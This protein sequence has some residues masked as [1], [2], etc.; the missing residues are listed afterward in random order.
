MRYSATRLPSVPL[1]TLTTSNI[2]NWPSWLVCLEKFSGFGWCTSI[3]FLPIQTT[4]QVCPLP[5]NFIFIVSN[6]NNS[7]DDKSE[8]W[9]PLRNLSHCSRLFSL[10]SIKPDLQEK[11]GPHIHIWSWQTSLQDESHVNSLYSVWTWMILPV[12]EKSRIQQ[13]S[14]MG[15]CW[16]G[17]QWHKN[18]A[19]WKACCGRV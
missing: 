18:S 10:L 8:I 7:F 5:S 17:T 2:T 12:R 4:K 16:M 1:L 6:S 19:K 3:H 15:S 11:G 13:C 9:C 14:P